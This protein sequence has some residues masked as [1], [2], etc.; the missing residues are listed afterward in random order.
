MQCE[1]IEN[2]EVFKDLLRRHA[3]CFQQDGDRHL[4]TT[5]DAEE[6]DVF[7]IELVVQP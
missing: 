1:I 3:D 2:E 4:T 5:I 7:R 6:Q